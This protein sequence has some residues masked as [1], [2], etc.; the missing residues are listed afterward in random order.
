[1]LWDSRTCVCVGFFEN[2]ENDKTA[3][4]CKNSANN[5]QQP[6]TSTSL[7][8]LNDMSLAG[9]NLVQRERGGNCS[10]QVNI[11]VIFWQCQ[12]QCSSSLF[13][14]GTGGIESAQS[15]FPIISEALRNQHQGSKR[16][17]E[18]SNANWNLTKQFADLREQW[19]LKT[20]IILHSCISGRTVALQLSLLTQTWTEIVS[21][22]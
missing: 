12:V 4:H 11:N 20:W 5:R 15:D 1:M 19:H 8:Q 7:N 17:F 16:A 6:V 3:R 18:T 9:I 10:N 22:C 13:S 14:S 21:E 2:L